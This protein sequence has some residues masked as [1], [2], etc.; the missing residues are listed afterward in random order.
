MARTDFAGNTYTIEAYDTLTTN[1]SGEITVELVNTPV[2]DKAILVNLQ[3]I[4][5]FARFS[6]RT[7][8][9]VTF[10]VLVYEKAS[11]VSG[12]S[13]TGLPVGVTEQSSKQNTDSAASEN[14][15]SGTG[16]SA[17]QGIADSF[18]HGHGVSFEYSHGH[19]TI[20]HSNTQFT[21]LLLTGGITLIIGYA[22]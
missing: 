10:K 6:S 5:A 16:A 8:K 7:G 21:P 11:A 9:N 3:G 2:D 17:G 1:G 14:V 18:S 15:N 22:F 12:G 4:D 20:T 13:L 19:D